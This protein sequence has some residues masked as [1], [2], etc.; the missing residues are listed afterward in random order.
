MEKGKRLHKN[1]VLN[2]VYHWSPSTVSICVFWPCPRQEEV[3]GPGIKP[4]AQWQPEHGLL[5]FMEAMEG[6]R[7]ENSHSQTE[8]SLKKMV[9]SREVGREL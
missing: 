4:T 5:T 2:H 3:P 1:D 9:N 6:I 7:R 8:K